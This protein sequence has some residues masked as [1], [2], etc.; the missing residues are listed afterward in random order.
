VAV[1]SVTVDERRLVAGGTSNHELLRSCHRRQTAHGK[2]FRIRWPRSALANE[3]PGS[4]I[5]LAGQFRLGHLVLTQ[6]D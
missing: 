3:L 4:S 2:V 1:R 6:D 5:A